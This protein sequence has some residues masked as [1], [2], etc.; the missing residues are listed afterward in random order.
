MLGGSGTLQAA[1]VESGQTECAGRHESSYDNFRDSYCLG[2]ED[3]DPEGAGVSLPI[4][5]FSY[6]PNLLI[7][8]GAVQGLLSAVA[9][10]FHFERE[11]GRTGQ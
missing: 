1:V 7:C 2:F 3:R 4:A 11:N 5:S 6:F 8:G 10:R 9:T